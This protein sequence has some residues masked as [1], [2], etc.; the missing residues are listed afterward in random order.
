[1]KKILRLKFLLATL[2]IIWTNSFIVAQ[3][4]QLVLSGYTEDVIADAV[5]NTLPSA[6]TST[7]VDLTGSFFF[8]QGYSNNAVPYSNGL[9][10]TGQFTSSAGHNFQLPAYN[11]NNSLRLVALQSG[12]LTFGVSDQIAYSALYILG[13]T[14]SGGN[15]VNYTINFD[16]ATTTAGSFVI[17]DW[18]CNSCTPYAIRDLSRVDVNGVLNGSNQFA[19]REHPISL[20]MTDQAKQVMSIDFS[21]PAGEP[22][23]TNIFGITGLPTVT[24]PVTLEYFTIRVEDSQAKLQWK[25]SQ[26]Y[27]SKRYIIERA[28]SSQSSAFVEVGEVP[29]SSANGAVYNFINVPGSPGVYFYRLI[30]E[31]IDGKK[32]IL[33]TKSI[34]LNS[35]FKWALQDLG[36]EWKLICDQPFQYRIIDMHGRIFRT[37][38]GAGSAIISK[39][40]V[41]GIYELQVQ[42][43]GELSTKKIIR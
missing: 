6:V 37:S 34:T 15:L 14:G 30:Q 8:V 20:S 18:F 33:G 19:I 17:D 10:V 22:G 13:T 40:S 5:L 25:T 31:D 35:K 7:S 39:P 23:A 11:A 28:N 1:M 32:K 43:G 16:D 24:V 36:P 4:R 29:S 41:R 42:T 27:N 3:E 2:C 26:E 12:T 21:V 38:T 9:P